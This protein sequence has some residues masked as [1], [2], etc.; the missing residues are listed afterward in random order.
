MFAN[1]A[2]EVKH[3]TNTRSWNLKCVHC[4]EVISIASSSR[5]LLY[6]RIHYNIMCHSQWPVAAH[7]RQERR[8]KRGQFPERTV[9]RS[10]HRTVARAPATRD[11]HPALECN[12]DG[13]RVG[14]TVWRGTLGTPSQS[15]NPAVRAALQGGRGH[16]FLASQNGNAL[17]STGD[18]SPLYRTLTGPKGGSIYVLWPHLRGTTVDSFTFGT[19][20]ECPT[21]QGW[22]CTT[23]TPMD[24]L[25]QIS[26][27]SVYYM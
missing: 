18:W 2:S 23:V 4:R 11:R 17:C 5:R 21:F 7:T 9:R 8:E 27:A 10:G 3:N 16:D 25:V 15:E 1:K 22:I 13:N 20:S 12:W 24:Q 14:C 6:R 19:M 26:I